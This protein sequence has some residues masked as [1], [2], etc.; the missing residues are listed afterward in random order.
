MLLVDYADLYCTRVGGSPGYREQLRVLTNRL[1]WLA[2]DLTAAKIDAYLTDA[3]HRLAPSTVQ[4]HRRMLSTLRRAAARDGLL[5]AESIQTPIR[6]VKHNLPVVRA[7]SHDEIRQLLTAARTMPGKTLRCPLNVLMPAWILFAYSSGLRRG[8]LLEVR[9]DQI[10]GNKLAVVQHKTGI[11]HVVALDQA[12]LDA[13]ATLPR[14]GP[15]IFGSLISKWRIK[16][17]LHKLVQRAK[18]SG[19]GKYLRRSSAT[20]AVIAGMDA[21]GHLGQLTPGLAQK[22]YVD[23]LLVAELKKPIPPISLELVDHA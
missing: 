5:T 14:Y 19:S 9:Y 1:P 23:P 15:K 12:A 4:N 20:Y 11:P 6:R 7:W 13:I 10:R 21:Q 16:T 8:D 2:S 22:H 18:L 17:V 3:L